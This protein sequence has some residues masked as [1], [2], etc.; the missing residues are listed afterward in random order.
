MLEKMASK[1][2]EEMQKAI[3]KIS[4]NFKI[5]TITYNNGSGKIHLSN[6][7][8]YNIKKYWNGGN[9]LWKESV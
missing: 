6:V 1:N 7:L 3:L 9:E 4:E 5:K 2:A 8:R